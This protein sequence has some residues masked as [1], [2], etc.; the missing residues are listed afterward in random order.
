M[1]PIILRSLL[2]DLLLTLAVVV[3]LSGGLLKLPT[4]LLRPYMGAK[5]FDLVLGLALLLTWA[6]YSSR[7]RSPAVS[8]CPLRLDRRLGCEVNRS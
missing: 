4:L 6:V 8:S 2:Y 7:K 5:P 3:L 1:L